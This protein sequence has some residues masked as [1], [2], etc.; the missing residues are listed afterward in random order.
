MTSHT[1]L[2]SV[3]STSGVA[4]PARGDLLKP[5]PFNT[6][7]TIITNIEGTELNSSNFGFNGSNNGFNGNFGFN[8]SNN[9]FNGNFSFNGSN[10]GFNGNFGFN[11][12]NNGFNGSNNSFNGSNNGFRAMPFV[13]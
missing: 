8:G 10:N 6:M 12:S 5:A 11:G 13:C 1:K 3:A 2:T 4:V 7:A 9:G